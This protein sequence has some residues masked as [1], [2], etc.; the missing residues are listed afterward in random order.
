MFSEPYEH[1][2]A[3]RRGINSVEQG[4][5]VLQA[6]VDL[7]KSASL[8]EIAQRTGLDSS[9][10]HRYV[11]S[12][13]NCGM[14]RQDLATGHYDLGPTALR[15]GLA[16]ISRI[17]ALTRAQD[18][19]RDF[20]N[21]SGATTL[22][23]V[24]A[25]GG[26]TIIRWNHGSPAF[27][28]TLTIGSV[29]PVTTSSAGRVFL[30]FLPESLLAPRLVAEGY[31]M[32]LD[33]NP[34]LLEERKRVRSAFMAAVESTVVVGIRAFSAPVLGPHDAIVATITV[35]ASDIVPRSADEEHRKGLLAACAKATTDIGG[36]WRGPRL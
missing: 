1:L 29:L 5:A 20:T 23:S 19:A 3:K 27:Y 34:V 11:S 6:V 32:P 10:T 22:L 25:I 28:T 16:A 8:K 18:A 26:P 30:A 33:K 12:L 14:L 2:G 15:T 35:I 13:V 24:W 9:Q 21:R 4:V 31:K 36:A 7:K 17:D